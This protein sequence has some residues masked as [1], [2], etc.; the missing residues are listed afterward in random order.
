MVIYIIAFLLVGLLGKVVG[1]PVEALVEAVA[2]RGARGLHVPLAVADVVEPELVGHLGDAH[3]LG[4]ILLVGEHEEHGVAQLV[5]TQHLVE[6]V[7]GLDDTLAVVR[8][9]DEDEALRILE[10]V[11]PQRTD[12]VLTAHIPH[13]EVDV[14]VL[15]GLHVEADG[16][17][18]GDDLAELELV[19]D[20]G[21]TSG[22]ETDHKNTHFLLTLK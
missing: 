5:L 1:K 12:L 11:A 17:D 18:G 15:D 10:V 21:L 7:V 3:R 22:I 16:G 8:V 14:L 9:D 6:L 20:G 4:E 19:E 2:G 13:G